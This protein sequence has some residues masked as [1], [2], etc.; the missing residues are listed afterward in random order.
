M[1]NI[2]KSLLVVLGCVIAFL[3]WS[4]HES[5][6]RLQTYEKQVS[7]LNFKSQYFSE[8]LNKDSLLIVEQQQLLLTKQQ[9]IDLGLLELNKERLKKIQYRI[10]TEYKI[11]IDSVFI[12]YR[13]TLYKS[14][15]VYPKDY[16][17][18]PK[19]FD[20]STKDYCINGLV[21]KDS[22][23]LEKIEIY[24]KVKVTLG[25]KKQGLFK[26]SIPIVEI[27]NSNKNIQ[28]EYLEN[29]VIKDKKR[30]YNKNSFW[31]TSG[32][33]IGGILTYKLMKL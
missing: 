15:T 2:S 29:L 5:R 17:L 14:D 27:E 9:A 8:K 18:I 6:V 10:K 24:N 26:N 28:T 1:K 31:L 12:K 11:L 25:S 33:V 19:R 7:N 3:V 20:L 21:L 4:I 30:F 16:I 13:D 22:L 32:T 23:L